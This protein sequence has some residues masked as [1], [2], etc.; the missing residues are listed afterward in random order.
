MTDLHHVLL[1]ERDRDGGMREIEKKKERR[2]KEK[3]YIRKNI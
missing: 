2:K 3:E 1:S